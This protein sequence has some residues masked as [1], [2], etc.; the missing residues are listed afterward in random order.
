MSGRGGDEGR[1][2]ERGKG[3]GEEKGSGGFGKWAESPIASESLVSQC[4]NISITLSRPDL[5]HNI[6]W[7]SAL[8]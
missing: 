7:H 3:T 8:S 1:R 6:L 4:L 5:L 2:L